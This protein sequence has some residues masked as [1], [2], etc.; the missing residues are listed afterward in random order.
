MNLLESG[1]WTMAE[2]HLKAAIARR[3]R[4]MKKLERI[5]AIRKLASGSAVDRAFVRSLSPA[6]Y[7]E[8]FP[9]R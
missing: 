5:A 4:A 9:A 7:R 3:F 8:A 1:K 6:L 2:R